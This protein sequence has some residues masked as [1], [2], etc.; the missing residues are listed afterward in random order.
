M[1]ELSIKEK[2]KAYDKAIERAKKWRNAPNV[3]KI[4]TYANRIIEEL[5]PELAG[6]EDERMIT[7]IES[8]IKH[9][10][11]EGETVCPYPFVSLDECLAWLKKQSEQEPA[12]PKFK[13]GDTVYY[14]SFGETKS[15][16]ID[17]VVDNGDGNPMYEDVKGSCIFEKD[18]IEQK[19]ADKVEP[20]F[21]VG[22]WIIFNG[23]TLYIKEIVKGYYRTISRDGI[24]N[25]YDWGI[26]NA[27]RLWTIQEA[28]DGDVLATKTGSSFVYKDF[29]YGKPNAYCGVDKFGVFKDCGEYGRDWT[30]YIHEVYPATKEQS[31]LL[32][33]KMREAGY[34]FDFDK[35]ELKKIEQKPA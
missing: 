21:H 7:G 32:F 27:A 29:A 10:K 6:P 30:P 4:P 11:D 34:T 12:K 3:D 16:I 26:D 19:P 15:M 33:R 24:T 1:K 5:F 20:K 22:D 25:S 8:I 17:T 13:I 9:Y 18:I 2:A 28:K 14:K 23:L 35:K 31:D